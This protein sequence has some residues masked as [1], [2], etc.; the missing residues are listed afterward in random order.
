V[1][2]VLS[3]GPDPTADPVGYAEAQIVPLRA[4]RTDDVSL[5]QV[6]GQLADAYQQEYAICPGAAS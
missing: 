6:L 4:V 2:A 1:S 3:D 5:R